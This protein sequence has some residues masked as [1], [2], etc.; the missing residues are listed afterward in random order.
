MNNQPIV[1]PG[2]VAIQGTREIR[3][4]GEAEF[5]EMWRTA[6]PVDRRM[7]VVLPVSSVYKG[8]VYFVRHGALTWKMMEPSGLPSAADLDRVAD[9]Q[10]V[11]DLTSSTSSSSTSKE[12]LS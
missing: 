7:D 8:G 2:V 10:R 6:F 11:A 1:Q 4:L 9:E 5:D 12:P 3:I